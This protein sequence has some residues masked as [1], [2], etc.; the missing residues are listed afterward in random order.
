MACE[1]REFE[2]EPEAQAASAHGGLPP[3]I[4]TT[5][6]VLDPPIPPK[7]PP[8]PIR[9]FPTARVPRIIATILLAGIG[10]VMLFELL[11]LFHGR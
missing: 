2:Y 6:G 3:G 10:A 7:R 9:L 4:W 5:A 8:G 11:L 1:F